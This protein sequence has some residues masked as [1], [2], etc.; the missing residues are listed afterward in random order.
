MPSVRL[1]ILGEAG[2]RL[3]TLSAEKNRGR[4]GSFRE[5]VRVRQPQEKAGV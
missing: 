4:P 2:K 5:R 1:L 3:L